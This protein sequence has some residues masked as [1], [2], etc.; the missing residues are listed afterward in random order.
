[1]KSYTKLLGLLMA[2]T[3]LGCGTENPFDR[4]PDYDTGTNESVVGDI[5]FSA[6]VIPALSGCTG[7][8]S[9]GT[10]GWTYDGGADAFAQVM[11]EVDL[12]SPESSALLVKGSG[13]DGHGGGTVI[14]TSSSAYADILA[15]IEA[16]ALDN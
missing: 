6:S 14:A 9:N 7:C 4:G 11:S 1:M 8:H 16:G 13:G 3:M 10:G 5:T 2:V 15:W 12:G